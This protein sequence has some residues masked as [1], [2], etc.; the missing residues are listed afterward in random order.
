LEKGRSQ[1]KKKRRNYSLARTN[2]TAFFSGKEALS[3]TQR[4][5]FVEDPQRTAR[6]KTKGKYVSRGRVPEAFR[7][8]ERERRVHRLYYP[9]DYSLTEVARAG[10]K[11]KI[12]S[13]K[14]K[15]TIARIS[16]ETRL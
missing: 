2:T 7:T 13:R 11:R 4:I 1:C 8:G 16:K 10:G 6:E 9:R 3:T 5:L 15:T 14:R 12:P